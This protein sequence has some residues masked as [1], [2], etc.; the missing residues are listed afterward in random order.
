MIKG[1]IEGDDSVAE[2]QI[3]EDDSVAENQIEG[4]AE[5]FQSIAGDPLTKDTSLL[6]SANQAVTHFE[7]RKVEI[8]INNLPIDEGDEEVDNINTDSD[9]YELLLEETEI[10]EESPEPEN[11]IQ[12]EDDNDNFEY[13]FQD[14]FLNVEN[15]TEGNSSE[16]ATDNRIDN[17]KVKEE[18]M[19]KQH[20][21]EL[22]TSNTVSD[23]NSLKI[24]FSSKGKLSAESLVKSSA[25][26]NLNLFLIPV[27]LI[28]NIIN[29]LV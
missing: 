10:N 23:V 4:N 24:N 17:V 16:E 8:E 1:Q 7:N 5:D 2:N 14:E 25:A 3:D 29:S 11:Y 22:F 20:N 18:I 28:S 9:K 21:N 12:H 13:V 6:V 15:V 27:F 19:S 26:S